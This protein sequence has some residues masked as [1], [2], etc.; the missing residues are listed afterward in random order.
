MNSKITALYLRI[1]K[2]DYLDESYSIQNQKKLLIDYAENSGFDNV[3]LFVDDGLTGV[4]TDREA[5]QRLLQLV[6][7]D[8]IGIVLVKDLSRVARNYIES[9]RY[10][11]ELFPL[12]SVR[13]ISINDHIDTDITDPAIIPFINIYNEF[14]SKDLSRKVKSTIKNI[15]KQKLPIGA[16][17]Y[18]YYSLNGSPHT[19]LV[20]EEAAE[21]VQFI[22]EMRLQNK[23]TNDIAAFLEKYKKLNPKAYAKK[24]GYRKYKDVVNPYSWNVSTITSMLKNRAYVGDVTNFKT[25]SKSFKLK[26]R[27]ANSKDEMS[28][29]ADVHPAII[30]EDMWLDV[31][32]TFGDTRY[33]KP[34]NV[35]RH[36]L[37]GYLYCSDCGS[38]LYFKH[39]KDNN[40][41]FSCG[42]NR[43]N[44][45]MCPETHHIRAD[46]A[47]Q[48]MVAEINALID[49]LNKQPEKII[50]RV[51]SRE[52]RF[53]SDEMTTLEKRKHELEVIFEHL[54]LDRI[55]L[56]SEQVYSRMDKK[57][58]EELADVL[59]RMTELEEKQ[60]N[61]KRLRARLD[62]LVDAAKSSGRIESLSPEMMR[63][64][65]ERVLVYHK[66]RERGETV[67]R[68][69]IEFKYIG[70][71]PKNSLMAHGK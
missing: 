57:Y 3:T 9:G 10:A 52:Q 11:E 54:V 39:I 55:S 18:G 31:Q 61:Q 33:R 50:D 19:W 2:Q 69:E 30:S 7:E 68:V 21:V 60:N 38:K 63:T 6:E 62:E 47:T 56:P 66:R 14:Y 27:I 40:D 59:N 17:P 23:S 46:Y 4:D 36:V 24:K 20:D 22:Y 15:D 34:K 1:S 37:A 48:Y 32:G 42:T 41:H 44:K 51:L 64:Y 29:H 65:I 70:R 5:L 49:L 25:Y 43:K 53:V 28:I 13:L 71:L 12:H 67:P 35:E 58:T 45:M 8:Q 16:P 26:K